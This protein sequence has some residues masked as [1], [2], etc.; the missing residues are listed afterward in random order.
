[1]YQFIDS[2]TER[3]E[4]RLIWAV[5]RSVME[6]IGFFHRKS[7]AKSKGNW[8]LFLG[9]LKIFVLFLKI[10][11]YYKKGYGNAKTIRVNEL[12]LNFPNLPEAFQGF[13]ILH[14]SDLH[15]DSIPGF[16]ALLIRVVKSLKFDICLLTGDYRKDIEG[17]F[18]HIIKPLNVLS[19]YIQAPYGTFAVLGNHDTYLMDRYAK[20]SGMELLIN[21]S[22]TITKAGEKILITGTDDPFNFYTES[23]LLS[24]ETQGYDFKIAMVHT[25][26]LARVASQNQYDLYLCGHTHGGQICLKEGVPIISHQF[27]GKQ[28]NHGLWQLGPMKGFTSRGAGVSGIPIRFNCPAEVTVI[29][30]TK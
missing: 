30:L 2:I 28:F 1:M 18:S 23:A 6:N 13:R 3:K 26:E 25:P 20:E 5:N 8:N 11:G 15:I 12:T 9:L 16:A 7:G 14:L 4:K 29:T 10:S 21:E 22:V 19:R 17:S 27:E 24:L